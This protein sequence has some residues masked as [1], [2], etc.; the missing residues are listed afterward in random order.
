MIGLPILFIHKKWNLVFHFL[1]GYNLAHAPF[2]IDNHIVVVVN[3]DSLLV[4]TFGE[5]FGVDAVGVFE[6]LL[7][8]FHLF[9]TVFDGTFE[10]HDFIAS[11]LINIFHKFL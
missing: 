9:L 6:N 8:A 1:D 4:H 3:F 5:V 10:E 2:D 11:V 7:Q